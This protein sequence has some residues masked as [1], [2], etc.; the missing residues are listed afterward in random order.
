LVIS[1]DPTIEFAKGFRGRM[2]FDAH[3]SETAANSD[4]LGGLGVLEMH[5]RGFR[6]AGVAIGF[7]DYGFDAWHPV[8]RDQ[9]NGR[10]RFR[11][12]VSQADGRV[13]DARLYASAADAGY[14]PHSDYYGP[15]GRAEPAAGAHGTHMASV[16]AGS[17][18]DGFVGA[19]PEADLFGVHLDLPD[20]AWT[21]RHRDGV[22]TWLDWDPASEPVW[23]GWRSYADATPIADAIGRL[24]GVMCATRRD[25]GS[26]YDGIV[27]NLSVGTWAG[28]HNGRSRVCAAI[29]EV[30]GRSEAGEGPPCMVVVGA[31]NAGQDGGH[32]HGRLGAAQTT[33]VEWVFDTAS[34]TPDKLEIWIARPADTP[35]IGCALSGP[36]GDQ[37]G[38]GATFEIV[39]GPT[40]SIEVSE[41]RCGVADYTPRASG[42]LDRIR[43][44]LSPQHFKNG[45]T[46]GGRTPAS[47][48]IALTCSER[49]ARPVEFHAWRERNDDPRR[50]ILRG[51]T[52]DGTLCDFACASKAVV[53]GGVA[54]DRARRADGACDD[55]AYP[56]V[57]AS[58]GPLP[59]LDACG[60]RA[61]PHVAAPAHLVWGA[62]S[63]SRGFA[64][65]SGTSASAALVSGA[66]AL[67]FEQSARDGVRL[68]RD[69]L[70]RALTDRNRDGGTPAGRWHPALGFGCVNLNQLREALV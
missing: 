45:F 50:S 59:W 46:G 38:D 67:M 35:V 61:A 25:D 8:F 65:T 64:P 54:L 34:T 70:V 14:D 29:D 31:G 10:T 56:L 7:A 11:T 26:P 1:I 44:S 6:G 2:M 49:A 58:R 12:I 39:P 21:E 37:P 18:S 20:T 52:Q 48:H 60:R 19:A 41:Q 13:I 15:A 4:V 17:Q 23:R 28:P 57:Y 32:V 63:L 22:P 3:S 24:Y 62:R 68:G 27:V 33:I 43:I 30:V 66:V 51:A 40:T 53:V 42:D 69:G 47:W 5:V 16:A 55:D 36:F 9:R